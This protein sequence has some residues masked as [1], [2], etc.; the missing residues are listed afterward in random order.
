M[1]DERIYTGF[2][3]KA[4]IFLISYRKKARTLNELVETLQTAMHLVVQSVETSPS[5][6][7][8]KKPPW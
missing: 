2:F 3:H 5:V 1:R 7:L 4:E 6:A 8:T